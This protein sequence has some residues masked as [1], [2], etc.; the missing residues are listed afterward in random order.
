MA[1]CTLTGTRTQ[2]STSFYL[3]GTYIKEIGIIR[4][5]LSL[6]ENSVRNREVSY[7]SREGLYA[8]SEIYL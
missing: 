3:I 4:R 6:S 5:L 2:M 1:Y 7:T 8:E